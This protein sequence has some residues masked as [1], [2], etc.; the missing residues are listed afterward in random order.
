MKK[1]RKIKEQLPRCG[2][3]LSLTDP[4]ARSMNSAGKGTGT[5]GYNVQTAVDTK[6]H[7]I[8][9]HEVINIGHDRGQLSEMYNL[10]RAI[11]ILGIRPLLRAIAT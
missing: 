4:D 8:V 7:M 5:V 2:G 11:N 6:N 3:Q 1:L 9:A 10:K